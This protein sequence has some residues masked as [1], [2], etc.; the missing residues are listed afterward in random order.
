MSRVDLPYRFNLR[1]YQGRVFDAFYNQGKRRIN[2]VWHRRAGKDKVGVNLIGCEANRAQ[3]FYAYVFPEK[4]MGRRILWDGVDGNGMRVIDHFPEALIY[5][6]SDANMSIVFRSPYDHRKPGSML[7]VLGADRNLNILVGSNVRGAVFSE[8]SIMNPRAWELTR[9]ILR[10]NGGWALFPYTPRGRNHGYTLHH[11]N[12]ANP[13]WYTDYLT[14][15]MTR[16]DSKWESGE[17][18]VTEAGIA[19]DRA[20]GMTETDIQQE[21]YCSWDAPVAG[22]YYAHEFMQIDADRRIQPVLWEPQYPVHTAWDLG[23]TEEMCIWFFQIIGREV[24]VIDY[25]VDNFRDLPHYCKLVRE[26]PY[27]Y[28]KHWGPHDIKVHSLSTGI[29]RWETAKNAGIIFDEVDDFSITEGINAVQQ[30][31]PRCVFDADKTMMGVAG[32][33]S[34]RRRWNRST[35]QW[36]EEPLHDW[37]SHPADSFRYAALGAWRLTG[38][39]NIGRGRPAHGR[40]FDP[41]ATAGVGYSAETIGFDPLGRY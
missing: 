6:K 39:E 9:P 5:R 36:L 11:T 33:R 23:F 8:F 12:I 2:L 18:V 14:V 34:Y 13:A 27:N 10:E 7:Q 31:L 29:T 35:Q 1:T 28:G 38:I 21:Y 16:R 19:E 20:E 41:F 22:A 25:H 4:E 24:R 26:K 32:L 30:L 17:R 15:D 40:D 3:G 37:A